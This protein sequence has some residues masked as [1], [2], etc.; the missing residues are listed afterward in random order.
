MRILIIF[1]T[2]LVGAAPALGQSMTLVTLG[3]SLT[4]GRG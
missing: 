2:L 1:L 3:D 4:A